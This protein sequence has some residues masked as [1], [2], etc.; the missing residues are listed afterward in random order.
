MVCGLRIKEI[1]KKLLTKEQNFDEALKKALGAEA[2]E[3][4]FAEVSQEDA[5]PVNKLDSDAWP[6]A[7]SSAQNTQACRKGPRQKNT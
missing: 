3:K 2:A 6:S 5:T 1:Q 7:L 4:Y